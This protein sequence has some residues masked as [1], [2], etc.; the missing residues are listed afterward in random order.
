MH[1]GD[2]SWEIF[3]AE[4]RS[5]LWL[6]TF[7]KSN[8][9][10]SLIDDDLYKN[11]VG[12]S[13]DTLERTSILRNGIR[14]MAFQNIFPYGP[15]GDNKIPV[16]LLRVSGDATQL[17]LLTQTNFRARTRYR[18]GA[19]HHETWQAKHSYR[20]ACARAK[21]DFTQE[22]PHLLKHD[23]TYFWAY[24]SPHTKRSGNAHCTPQD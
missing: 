11:T 22:L 14:Y 3:N 4:S 9:N 10:L 7:L 18:L 17:Q 5:L 21:Y 15:K 1:N 20:K 2:E 8:C 24:V 19:S 13:R 23:P 6:S 12:V 16:T